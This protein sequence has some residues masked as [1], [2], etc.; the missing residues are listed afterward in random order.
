MTRNLRI[1]IVAGEASGDI[2]GAGL[3]QSIKEKYPEATFEGIGGTKMCA[4]GFNS[5]V[6]I[7]RL[8]VMGLVEVLGRLF[9]LIKVRRNLIQHFLDNPPDVFIGIDAP[10]FNLALEKKLKSAGIKTVQYV[11]P[12]V[13]AWRQY[14]VKSI[15]QSVDLILALFPFE[16]AFYQEHNVPVT[17]VGHPLADHI[18]ME[19][20]KQAARDELGLQADDQV[21][22]LLPGSRMGEVSRL[23]AT[24]L[25]SAELCQ[26]EYP[27][28]KVLVAAANPGVAS[29]IETA[30][31]ANSNIKSVQVVVAQAQLVMAAADAL[32]LASG[33]VTLEAA[34]VKRPMVIAYKMQPLTHWML[35]RL[36]KIPYIALPNLL[37]GRDLVPEFVQ[38]K[39]EPEFIV[40]AL[41]AC[42]R[43]RKETKAQL[44]AFVEIHQML[45]QNAS[46]K[47][48]EAVI[49]LVE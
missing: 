29:L 5:H 3:I 41:I 11:S 20:S 15:G 42:L 45:R 17:F 16:E 2:L 49:N 39:A 27:D 14:R 31:Q 44:D 28:C 1:G 19:S 38:Q 13:W 9:E 22:A 36:V 40:P 7:E 12:Q 10:D 21:L 23:I 37:A 35:S 34:L 26:K 48:A 30:I 18:P 33:T 8:S 46:D 24:F 6:P 43:D 4:L 25:S 32:L 47:A